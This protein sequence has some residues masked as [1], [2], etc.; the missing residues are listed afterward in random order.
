M[1]VKQQV[2]PEHDGVDTHML[3]HLTAP[4]GAI[5]GPMPGSE[6]KNPAQS[7]GHGLQ[8]QQLHHPGKVPWCEQSRFLAAPFQQLAFLIPGSKM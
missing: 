7:P 4:P 3:P 5:W 6:T 2:G 1:F 8:A